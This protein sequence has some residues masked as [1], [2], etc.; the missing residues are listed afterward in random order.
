M[1]TLEHPPVTNTGKPRRPARVVRG[2]GAFVV[3][4]AR[5]SRVQGEG[6]QGAGTLQKP[7]ERSVDSGHQ[8]HEAWLLSVQTRLYK[9]S[10][11]CPA[12]PRLLES[13]MHNERCTSGSGRGHG[14]PTAVTP[15]GAHVLLYPVSWRI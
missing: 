1:G 10:R 8:A 13:R 6:R 14:K 9:R 7:E 12:T 11:G 2:G 15:H 4:G 3:V 5:E